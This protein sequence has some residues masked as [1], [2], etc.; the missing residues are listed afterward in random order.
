MI[1]LHVFA[2][3]V[4]VWGIACVLQPLPAGT[5]VAP[6]AM[7][8]DE[9][10]PRYTI[11]EVMKNAHG[12]NNLVKKLLLGKA[13]VE[14]KTALIEYYVALT[15]NL[16]PRGDAEAWKKSTEKLLAAAKV[17]VNGNKQDLASLRKAVD[18][19][20]CHDAHRPVEDQ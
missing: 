13:T 2:A 4:L 19:K 12:K 7:K 20:A 11:K 3:A 5:E 6:F 1:R 14:E 16:P 8:A 9:E 10:R 15:K 18:C 17:A